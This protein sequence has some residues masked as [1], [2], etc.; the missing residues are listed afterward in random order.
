MTDDSLRFY[1]EYQ[2]QFEMDLLNLEAIAELK[3]KLLSNRQDMKREM[4]QDE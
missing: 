4:Q 2:Q 3:A 1:Q